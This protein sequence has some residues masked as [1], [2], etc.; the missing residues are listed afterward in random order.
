MWV[1]FGLSCLAAALG[2]T[3]FLMALTQRRRIRRG[4]R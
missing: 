3:A 4:P 2:L 1:G